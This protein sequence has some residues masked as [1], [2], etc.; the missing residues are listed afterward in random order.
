MDN[1]KATSAVNL[2]IIQQ[3]LFDPHTCLRLNNLLIP[4]RVNHNP[5]LNSSS[6][7]E[8][9][10]TVIDV[11]E[12]KQRQLVAEWKEQQEDSKRR[13]REWEREAIEQEGRDAMEREAME[14]ER[15]REVMPVII[16]EDGED[17]LDQDG[18]QYIKLRRGGI[19]KTTTGKTIPL[20]PH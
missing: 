17:S 12:K 10:M 1:T 9:D 19:Q 7:P 14:R 20:Y 15:E 5:Y 11:S 2:Y 18:E 16:A 6:E 13:E 4:Q 8:L 3:V